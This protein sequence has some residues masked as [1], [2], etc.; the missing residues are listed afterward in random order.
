MQPMQSLA[1]SQ[2]QFSLIPLPRS[3]QILGD[4]EVRVKILGVGL[5]KSDVEIPERFPEF[6]VGKSNI[7]VGFEII[8]TNFSTF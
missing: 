2:K 3:S 1:L 4:V 7:P 5:S 8:G 6:C